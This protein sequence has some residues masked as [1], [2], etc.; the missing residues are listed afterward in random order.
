MWRSLALIL[1]A[2][3]ASV[4]GVQAAHGKPAPGASALATA[5]RVIEPGGR[6]ATSPEPP[7]GGGRTTLA[8]F[9]YP[10]DGAVVLSGAVDATSSRSIAAAAASAA[11]A[12]NVANLSLFDGEIT[13]DSVSARDAATSAGGARGGG[14]ATVVHLQALGRPI[15][16]GV[17]ALGSWGSL[18][19]G[20]RSVD[21]NA[22]RG[23]KSYESSEIGVLVALTRAHDGLPA[24]SLI[25]VA[26]TQA[27]A[28]TAPPPSP[29]APPVSPSLVPG[30]RPQLLPAPSGPL[31]GVPQVVE[32]PLGSGA[33][34]FPVYGRVRYSD[35]YGTL[36]PGVNYRH[37]VDI[38]GQLG[39]PL[40]AVASG[41][42]YAVGWT[43][44]GGNRLWLRDS[45]GN[46]FY[47]SHLSAFAADA[48]QGAHVSAGEVIGFMGDT[49][50]TAGEPNHLEFEVHPVS[51]LYLGSQ[52]AVDPG[53][54]LAGWRRVAAVSLAPDTG[55]APNVRAT[56]A[57]PEPGAILVSSSNI[58]SVGAAGS[59]ALRRVLTPGG[60]G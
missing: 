45:D 20:A 60:D 3:L 48:V 50:I 52:G 17:V 54:Y 47:Y 55:W 56:A 22:P 10:G 37:G 16:R 8:S 30:D 44:A 14:G 43:K 36:G 32:P 6:G 31:V 11:A 18:T 19:V 33:Y 58:A 39:Q 51:L 7:A 26:V 34:V 12:A 59:G 41:T 57:A 46:E 23:V 38:F 5:V 49:G 24:G 1:T 40:V 29:P 21:R 28:A 15:S 2:A 53:P 42:L 9:A 4:P 13:A 35:D 25:E 27:A